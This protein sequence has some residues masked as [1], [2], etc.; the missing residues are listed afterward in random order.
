MAEDAFRRGRRKILEQFL[1]RPALYNAAFFRERLEAPARA[2]LARS[3]AA[4]GGAPG[5]TGNTETS[6]TIWDWYY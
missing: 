1:A 5:S 3:I 4:L 2:N 6:A